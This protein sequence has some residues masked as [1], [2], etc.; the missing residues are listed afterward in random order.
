MVGNCA[1]LRVVRSNCARN[2]WSFTA[3]K[4][5]RRNPGEKARGEFKDV[6]RGNRQSFDDLRVGRQKQ[7]HRSHPDRARDGIDRCRA[8]EAKACAGRSHRYAGGAGTRKCWCKP[9][10]RLSSPGR[11]RAIGRRI[12]C[13]IAI[14]ASS[15]LAL[16]SVSV[17]AAG[18]GF[19][20]PH[21][22]SMTILDVSMFQRFCA[23]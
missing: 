5:L 11:L 8:G 6:T 17:V 16:A 12:A 18:L 20:Q 2:N 22:K 1:S 19:T 14:R 10:S 23:R 13:S 7:R 15:S 4:R 9:C 21:E 3:W